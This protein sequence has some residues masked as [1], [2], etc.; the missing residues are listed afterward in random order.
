MTT[1]TFSGF[2]K[3][4]IITSIAKEKKT[5]RSKYKKYTC[6]AVSQSFYMIEFFT[7]WLDLLYLD[8]SYKSYFSLKVTT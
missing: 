8:L 4:T 2:N 5:K 6:L 7:V 3:T 1:K